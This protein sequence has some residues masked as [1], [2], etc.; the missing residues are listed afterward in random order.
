MVHQGLFHNDEAPRRIT[1][2]AIHQAPWI[3]RSP[4]TPRGDRAFGGL[5][6]TP[7]KCNDVFVEKFDVIVVGARC[8]GA[9]TAMLLTRQGLRVLLLDLHH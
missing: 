4:A 9:P 6:P 8:A 2:S 1:P 7:V 5:C 3:R